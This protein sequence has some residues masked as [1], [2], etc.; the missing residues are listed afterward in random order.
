MAS[1]HRLVIRNL[2]RTHNLNDGREEMFYLNGRKGLFLL[3]L[4]R[5]VVELRDYESGGLWT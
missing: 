1:G 3:G 5:L 4:K 2:L